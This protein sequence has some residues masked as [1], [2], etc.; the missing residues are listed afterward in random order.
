MTSN[1]IPTLYENFR[2]VFQ[3]WNR[4]V[5]IICQ[6]FDPLS[7]PCFNIMEIKLELGAYESLG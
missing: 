1:Q 4:P 7:N 2:A 3:F 5:L 6:V